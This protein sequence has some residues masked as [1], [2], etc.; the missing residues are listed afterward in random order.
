MEY[1]GV[2]ESYGN[3]VYENKK[4]TDFFFLKMSLGSIENFG[5]EKFWSKKSKIFAKIK[6]KKC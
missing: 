6:F 5:I 2:L 1:L 4:T 3:V